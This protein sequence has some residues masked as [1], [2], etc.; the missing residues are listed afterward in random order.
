MDSHGRAHVVLYIQTVFQMD[1]STRGTA[2]IGVVVPGRNEVT[3]MSYHE[4]GER[5]FVASAADNQLQVIDCLNGK[6]MGP[7]LRC[8]R[9]KIQVVEAT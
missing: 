5:L 9:E 1:F 4:K 2:A 7:P 8:E 6:A 3:C